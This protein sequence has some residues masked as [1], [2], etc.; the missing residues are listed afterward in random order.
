M[1]FRSDLIGQHG[2]HNRTIRSLK[3]DCK[4]LLYEENFA[5]KCRDMFENNYFKKNRV[6]KRA[7]VKRDTKYIKLKLR[8]LNKELKTERR[9]AQRRKTVGKAVN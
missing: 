4:T 6:V 1:E 9:K 2:E 7:Q 3:R 5:H 8:V